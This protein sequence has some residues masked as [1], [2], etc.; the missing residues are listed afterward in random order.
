MCYA[1]TLHIRTRKRM[2]KSFAFQLLNK[3]CLHF[4]VN[5]LNEFLLFEQ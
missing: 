4:E 2:K 5:R 3:F 1:S